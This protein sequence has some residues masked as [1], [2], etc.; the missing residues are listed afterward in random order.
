MIAGV[1]FALLVAALAASPDEPA[2]C[3]KDGDDLY[4]EADA[5]MAEAARDPQ[6]PALSRTRERLRA[7]RR[8]SP[9]VDRTLQGADLAFAAGDAEEG[10]DLLAAAAERNNGKLTPAELF[11]VARRAEERRRWREAIARYAALARM[12]DERGEDG[13][14]IQAHLRPLILEA[15]A[16]EVAPPGIE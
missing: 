11:L 12:L 14:L 2:G 3:I 15:E 13:S 4:A 9:S 5:L 1:G 16:A 6:G 8:L 10:V 7:A